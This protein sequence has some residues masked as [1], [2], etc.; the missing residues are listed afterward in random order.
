MVKG[1]NTAKIAGMILFAG[2]NLCTARCARWKPQGGS[3]VRIR[4]P[5]G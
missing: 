1:F 2:G 5:L 4:K 3:Q